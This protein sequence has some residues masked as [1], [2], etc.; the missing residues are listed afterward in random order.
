MQKGDDLIPVD[1]N[2]VT[3]KKKEGYKITSKYALKKSTK[4]IS[5]SSKK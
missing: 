2:D 5:D 3:T 1:K 4:T